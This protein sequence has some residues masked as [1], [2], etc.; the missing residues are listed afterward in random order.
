MYM[1]SAYFIKLKVNQETPTSEISNMNHYSTFKTK[2]VEY[3]SLISKQTK[4]INK[5]HI[6][7]TSVLFSPSLLPNYALSFV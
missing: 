3:N 7:S 2:K 5:Q 4:I 1:Y 6:L